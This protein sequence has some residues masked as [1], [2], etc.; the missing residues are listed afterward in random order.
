MDGLNFKLKWLFLLATQIVICFSS[1]QFSQF[2]DEEKKVWKAQSFMPFLPSHFNLL[3]VEK[4]K[5]LSRFRSQKP[6]LFLLL[7]TFGQPF[8][9]AP[10]SSLTWSILSATLSEDF[11]R[12]IMRT[13]LVNWL[14]II[15]VLKLHFYSK[16]FVNFWHKL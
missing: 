2:C 8:F 4:D 13:V 10:L 12:R 5:N 6:V 3:F 16:F 14:A 7:I 15:Y 9:S 11:Y 1:N